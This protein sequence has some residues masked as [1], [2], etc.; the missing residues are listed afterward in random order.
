MCEIKKNLN[1]MDKFMKICLAIQVFNLPLTHFLGLLTRNFK[2]WQE[3]MGLLFS[4][5]KP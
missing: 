3:M 4:W 2:T 5:Y 1:F